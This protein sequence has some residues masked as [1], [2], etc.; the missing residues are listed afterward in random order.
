MTSHTTIL[1][2]S[3]LS[4]S[5]GILTGLGL[6]PKQLPSSLWTVSGTGSMF[7]QVDMQVC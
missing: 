3:S 4:W 5:W 6:C 2:L 7:S 1:V